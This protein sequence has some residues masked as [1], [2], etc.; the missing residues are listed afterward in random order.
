YTISDGNGGN[1][2][3][4]TA[5]VTMTVGS[6]NFL[7]M[8]VSDIAT[9]NEDASVTV[10][11]LANDSDPDDDPLQIESATSPTNGV[12][13]IVNNSIVYTP[14][15][16]FNGVDSFSY[17]AN[18]GNGGSGTATVT[19]TV[20][21]VND[22][23]MAADDSAATDEDTAV[24]LNVLDNDTDT[25]G[26]SLTVDSVTQGSNGSVSTDGTRV[27]YTPSANFNGN[28][29]FTYTIS[30]G[31]GGSDTALVEITVDATDGTIEAVID[32][33]PGRSTNVI[34]V[35]S[36]Q[37]V[38]VLLLGSS[39][40]NV[41]QIDSSTLRFGPAE[42]SPDT[43]FYFDFNRDGYNDIFAVFR[44]SQTGIALG[45]EEACLSGAT[46]SG[47]AF[48]ACDSIVTSRAGR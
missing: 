27:T 31:N 36:R 38:S 48:E 11:V 25:D 26:D 4:A 41:T 30:D 15:L 24:T 22:A 21:A 47:E 33:L 12:V 39:E 17:T 3:S 46:Y 23:P 6:M 37:R 13:S 40:L 20:N 16:N 14:T 29:S 19:I 1:G 5:T 45:D 18:D 28:D 42:A 34:R 43:L 32:I 9:T 2:G 44:A 7:P 35:G 10:D 8:I